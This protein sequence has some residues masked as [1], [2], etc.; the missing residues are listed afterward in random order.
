MLLKNSFINQ[1]GAEISSVKKR[2]V[3]AEVTAFSHSGLKQAGSKGSNLGL[4]QD[5]QSSG[6]KVIS[7]WVLH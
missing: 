3:S 7:F 5:L 1:D 6:L 2:T 4:R